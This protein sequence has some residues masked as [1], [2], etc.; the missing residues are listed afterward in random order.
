M[1]STSLYL[2]P[3]TSAALNALAARLRRP[4]AWLHREALEDLLAK[5]A[6]AKAAE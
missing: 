6:G 5:Y 3:D 2:P 4:K 1:V